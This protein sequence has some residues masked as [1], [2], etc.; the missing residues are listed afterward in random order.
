DLQAE[1]IFDQAARHLASQR[2]AVADDVDPH[3]GARGQGV[4]EGAADDGQD[5]DIGDDARAQHAPAHLRLRQPILDGALR[6]VADQA[7]FI[8]HLVH[9]L[10]AGVHAGAAAYAH[11]LQAVADVDAGRTD[12][13]TQAAIHAVAHAGF[14]V[15]DLAGPPAAFFTAHEVVG[16]HEGVAVHH[17]ALEPSVGTHVLAHGLAHEA[18]V[19]PGGEGV[20][21]QPEPLPGTQ[22][23]GDELAAQL[24]DGGKLADE[25]LARPERDDD[26]E[27]MLG[28]LDAQLPGRPGLFVQADAGQAVAFDLALDPHEDFGVDGLGTGVAAEQPPGHGREQEQ[29]KGGDQQQ[30]GQVD[31][32][33]RPEDHAEDIE[34]AFQQVEQHGLAA[35]PFDPGQTIE[36]DLREIHHPDPPAGEH[37]RDG[38]GIDLLAYIDQRLLDLRRGASRSFAV[39]WRLPLGD[40]F[41]RTVGA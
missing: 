30:D 23:Q 8:A 26:P 41:L 32:V 19:A 9:D 38:A 18:G 27:E 29:G 12:L 35:M 22:R 11:V 21:Q 17:D 2:A 14:L 1:D 10:V 7:L 24:A 36:D 3:R 5:Q 31:D 39:A 15:V 28:G 13:H 25:R 20:E 33:L 40:V 34:L 16:D 4:D 6:G 37:A